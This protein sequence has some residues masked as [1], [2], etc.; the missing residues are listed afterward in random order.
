MSDQ[1]M[2][3]ADE[4]TIRIKDGA[5]PPGEWLPSFQRISDDLNFGRATV[6]RA[7]AYLASEGI[8]T[9]VTGNGYHHGEQPDHPQA[10]RGGLRCDAGMS[11]DGRKLTYSALLG[12]PYITVMELARFLKVSKMTVYR[13]INEGADTRRCAPLTEDGPASVRWGSGVHRRM[14]RDPP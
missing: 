4:I 12:N 11:R 6:Q 8:I 5:Y 3:C 9:H 14:R 2:T 13:A 7:L 1:W 10:V